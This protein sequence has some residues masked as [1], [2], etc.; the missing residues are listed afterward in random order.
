MNSVFQ[1]YLRDFVL[2]FFDDIL[3]YSSNWESHLQHL[4]TVL[5]AL[6]EQRLHVKLSKCLFAQQSVQYLGHVVSASGLSADPSKISAIQGWPTPANVRQLRSFLGLARYYR[7]FIKGYARIAAPLTNSICKAGFQ[8]MVEQQRAFDELKNAL[9]AAPVLQLPDFTATFFVD[10]DASGLAMGAVLLQHNHPLAYFSKVFSPTI[11]KASTY[12][13]E[14]YAITEAVHKWR[15]YL[16]GREFVIQT[17]H[18]SLQ[19]LLTQPI[20]T[21]EQEQWLVKLLGYQYRV[22][23]KP[24]K[25]NQ[26]RMPYL[27]ERKGAFT[28]C[29]LLL[30]ISLPEYSK[31]KLRIPSSKVSCSQ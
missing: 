12:V 30:L 7:R 22:E 11:R 18:H 26:V 5:T 14:L 25:H 8:W 29:L 20:H 17:D 6:Q 28:P 15:H 23:Y 27:G 10:T 13:R 1:R 16:L 19:H 24:G 21:P 3:V 4:H 31:H 2:V 9:V